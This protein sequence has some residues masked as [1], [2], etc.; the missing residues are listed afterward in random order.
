MAVGHPATLHPSGPAT[1]APRNMGTIEQLLSTY[2]YIA[3]FIGTFLEGETVLVVGAFLAQRGYLDLSWVIAAALAGALTGDQLFYRLGRWKGVALINLFDTL[4]RRATKG[5]AMLRRNQ[6]LVIF[7]FR[8]MYGLRAVAPFLIGSSG[9]KPTRFALM[10]LAGATI[11][12]FAVAALGFFAGQAYQTYFTRVRKYE[13]H[14]ALVLLV[15]GFIFWRIRLYRE[16]R[17]SLSPAEETT[18]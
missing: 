14:A 7:G 11:W 9:V 2:G 15:A 5:L 13:L 16:R 8:F 18:P 17:Q 12:T 4:R 3:I 1:A 10:N 6:N